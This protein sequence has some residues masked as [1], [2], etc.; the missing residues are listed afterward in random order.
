VVV[1][2]PHPDDETIGAGGASA[3][4]VAIGDHVSVVVVTDGG[5]SHAG[6]LSRSAMI[7][8]RHAEV[9]AA[10]QILGVEELVCL[11][12]PESQW[13]FDA[14]TR[15]LAPLIFPADIVY[16]P[17]CVD[18]HPEHVA[19]ARLVAA[20]IQPG[21]TVRVYQIGVPLTPTLTNVVADISSL[22]STK[23]HALAAHVTQAQSIAPLQR[24]SRY[25]ARLYRLGAV[26][27]FCEMRSE[28]Y[29]AVIP[30]DDWRGHASPYRG[31]RPRPFSDP[32]AYVVGARQRQRLRRLVDSD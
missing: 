24:L 3:L 23:A 1:V 12:L 5:A 13:E 18:Y 21:R 7:S 16:A 9:C 28:T 2:A 14:A 11:G 29:A 4:H 27:T 26:E 17:G 31:I 32:L 10:V 19:V 22:A 20:T 8:R 25:D 6:G 30:A 15:L